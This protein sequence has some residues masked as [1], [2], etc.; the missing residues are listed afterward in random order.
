MAEGFLKG[1][2]GKP[3]QQ[4]T[5]IMGIWGTIKRAPNSIFK[6]IMSPIKVVGILITGTI[7]FFIYMRYRKK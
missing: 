2:W 3:T 1:I 6:T 5:G 4:G 7:I